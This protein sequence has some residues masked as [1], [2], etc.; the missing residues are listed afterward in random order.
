MVESETYPSRGFEVWTKECSLGLRENMVVLATRKQDEAEGL[1]SRL[2]ACMCIA[3]YLHH[4]TRIK[5]SLMSTSASSA[6][7]LYRHN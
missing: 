2:L 5:D 4:G 7:C 1:K 6:K 3:R